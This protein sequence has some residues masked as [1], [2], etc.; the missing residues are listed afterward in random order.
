VWIICNN[1]VV[2]D[3]NLHCFYKRRESECNEPL[4]L[5]V[6]RSPLTKIFDEFLRLVEKSGA[7][8]GDTVN[9]VGLLGQIEVWRLKYGRPT[10]EPRH[11]AIESGS[12]WPI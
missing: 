7:A 3:D 9:A 8:E 11:P 6:L 5:F 12:P 4:V 1:F 2:A 10:D